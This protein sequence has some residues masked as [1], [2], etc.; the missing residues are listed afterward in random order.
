[1]I[2]VT[3]LKQVHHEILENT[4]E[5]ISDADPNNW[6]WVFIIIRQNGSTQYS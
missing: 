2:I 3:T 5:H 4:C 6:P 1:M